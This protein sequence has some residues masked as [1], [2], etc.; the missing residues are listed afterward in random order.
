MFYSVAYYIWNVI[1][2]LIRQF[3]VHQCSSMAA[4]LAYTT[5][6]SIV[7]LMLVSLSIV[8]YF[9]I[10]SD[11]SVHLQKFIITNFVAGSADTLTHYLDQFIK[12]MHK[13]SWTNSVA[14]TGTSLLLLYNMVSA[15][16]NIWQVK[17]RKRFALTFILYFIILLGMPV[18]FGALM[19]FVSYMASLS[20]F[21]DIFFS[22]LGT[23]PFFILLPFTAMIIIFTLFNWVLPS[24]KVRFHYAIYAGLATSVFFELM[25]N[26]FSLYI[27]VFPTYRLIYGALATVPIF[28]VWVYLSWVIILIG[29][30]LCKGMHEKFT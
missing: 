7:P 28:F 30:L 14:F 1:R 2:Y 5:L 24:C 9:P 20:L 25:K 4:G 21:T 3:S 15:F 13:L 23:E 19:L 16:N 6:L 29:V 12:Q 10:F 27:R 22:R 17:M 11:A 18:L 26:L 8:S